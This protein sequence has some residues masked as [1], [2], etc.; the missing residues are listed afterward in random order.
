MTSIVS[1]IHAF[2][3]STNGIHKKHILN[4]I[5]NIFA[6]SLGFIHDEAS[7]K[8]SNPMDNNFSVPCPEIMGN[9]R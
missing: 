6:I 8:I 7:P 9:Y 4:A 1:C 2:I 3:F 5:S